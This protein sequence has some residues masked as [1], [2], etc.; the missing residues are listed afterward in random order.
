[1]FDNIFHI[2]FGSG[3]KPLIDFTSIPQLKFSLGFTLI[4]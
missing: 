2:D 3:L 4:T 1:M